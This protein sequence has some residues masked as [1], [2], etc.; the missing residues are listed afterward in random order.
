MNLEKIISVAAEKG[1]SDI[2]FA[3]GILPHLRIAGRMIPGGNEEVSDDFVNEVLEKALVDSQKEKFAEEKQVDFV[4]KSEGGIRLRG[5]AFHTRKGVSLALRLIA[6]EIRELK[7]LGFPDT[8]MGK[9]R[10]LKHGLVLVVGATGQGKSTTLA[11]ILHDLAKVRPQHLITIEDPIEYVLKSEK[12]VVQQREVG[13][14]VVDFK[15][16]IRAALREDPDTLMVG[17]MRDHETISSVLTMAETGHVVF[18]TLHTSSGP[19]TISRIIDVFPSDQQSQVRSQL[20]GSLAMII[21]QRLIPNKKGGLSLAYE[22]LTNNY[23][24]KNYIR[25]NKVYQIPSA[26]QTD[27]SGDMVQLE[28]S[29]AG[30]VIHDLVDKDVALEY[31][32]DKEQLKAIL[33]ANGVE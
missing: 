28:Q 1:A 8:V 2:H 4:L 5:N 21:S 14:D 3:V 18:S 15:L 26:L 11:S 27:S 32:V 10:S 16:G 20:A 33:N 30:L 22:V 25:D 23:A 31:A 13:R 17:E 19:Q 6:D 12:T 29:L 9:I 7:S 24:V